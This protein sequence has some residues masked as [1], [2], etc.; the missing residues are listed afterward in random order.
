MD[1]ISSTDHTQS[2]IRSTDS[3]TPAIVSNANSKSPNTNSVSPLSQYLIVPSLPAATNSKSK[4]KL[5]MARLLTSDQCL[6]ELEEKER[7]KQLAI[8]EKERRKKERETKRKQKE[9]ILKEKKRQREE[10]ARKKAAEKLKKAEGKAKKAQEK[11][12]AQAERS[13]ASV[14]NSRQRTS[15]RSLHSDP[16][17]ASEETIASKRARSDDSAAGLSRRSSD[18]SASVMGKAATNEEIDP[19]ICC[20][21]FVTFEEDTLEGTGAEWLPCHCGRWLHEDCAENCIVDSDGNERF[22]PF[23]LDLLSV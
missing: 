21:C 19:N 15:K 17:T 4:K 2:I 12:N 7:S 11:A 10:N 1:S 8:E 9:E 18:P 22:C 3:T 5:P 13:R 23:C 6:A 14:S 20:M 16:A